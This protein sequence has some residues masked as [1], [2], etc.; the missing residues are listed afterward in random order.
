VPIFHIWFNRRDKIL[1]SVSLF[2]L[3]WLKYLN[4]IW[5]HIDR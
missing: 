5:L 2:S 1:A 4:K 3:F